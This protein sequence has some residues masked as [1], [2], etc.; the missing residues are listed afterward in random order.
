MKL[1]LGR[2]AEYLGVPANELPSTFNRDAVATGYSIDSRTINLGEVFFAV[3]GE[4][5]DGHDF[6]TQ[7]FEQLLAGIRGTPDSPEFRLVF[8]EFRQLA[9]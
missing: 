9:K 1:P 4:R 3:R 8:E 7:A 5:M 2:I 6:L